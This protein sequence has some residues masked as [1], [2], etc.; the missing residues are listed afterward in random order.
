V[1]ARYVATGYLV[2]YQVSSAG[3]TVI[4]LT[5]DSFYHGCPQW[6]PDGNWVVYHKQDATNCYQIYKTAS[7]GIEEKDMIHSEFQNPKVEVYPNPFI[8]EAI[9]RYSSNGKCNDNKNTSRHIYDVSGRLVELTKG[10]MI[11]KNLKSGIYFLKTDGC[12]MIKIVKLR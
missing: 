9:I 4:Q 10:S 1:Y 6:S 2:I 5:C 8:T 3:G 7:V 12:K 11:G